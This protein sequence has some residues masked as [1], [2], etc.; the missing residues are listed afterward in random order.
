VSPRPIAIALSAL[1][2]ATAAGA[3]APAPPAASGRVRLSLLGGFVPGSRRFD[4]TRAL[5][6][7]QEAGRI[8]SHYDERSGPGFEGG[9]AFRLTPRLGVAG[10]ASFARRSLAGSFSA[11]L[12]HPLYF[13]RLRP[14]AGDLQ[15]GSLRETGVHLDLTVGGG[16]RVQWTAFA[17]PSVVGVSTDLLRS[18]EYAQAYPYDAVTVTGT[19]MGRAS[20]HGVGFNVGA[21]LDWRIAGHVAIG[22]QAR[23]TRARIGLQAE[24]TDRVDVDAGG[25]LVAAGL[26]LDF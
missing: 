2:G 1:L 23:F 21:G 19:P 20:G 8:E 24:G 3:E 18:V 12:P 11:R 6:E 14:A 16:G 9:L 13:D 5:T 4:Q 7:F 26:R 22:T 25:V 17:G 15:Q 10:A